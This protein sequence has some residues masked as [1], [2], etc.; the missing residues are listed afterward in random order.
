M[1]S[2][3]LRTCLRKPTPTACDQRAVGVAQGLLRRY[4]LVGTCLV[5]LFLSPASGIATAS[6][7]FDTQSIIQLRLTADFKTLTSADDES[8]AQFGAATL[9]LLQDNE[10]RDLSVAL[11]ARGK[12]R[13]QKNNCKFPL[14]FVRFGDDIQDTPFEGTRVLPLTTHC[15]TKKVYQDYLHK[16][17]LLYQ[18]FS[19][20]TD[21]SLRTRMAKIEYVD[22]G[23]NNRITESYALFVEH[24]DQAADRLQTKISVA[25]GRTNTTMSYQTALVEVFQYMIGNTDWSIPFG[26]NIL[27]LENHEGVVPVPFDFDQ[28]GAINTEYAVPSN[29]LPIKRVTQRLFRGVCKPAGISN[30]AI[31]HIASKQSEIDALITNH[32]VMSERSS[33]RMKKYFHRFFEIARQPRQREKLILNECR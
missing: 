30:A 1:P 23:R 15:Q 31:D 18:V 13:L 7:L 8:E 29:K 3:K 14:F 5:T 24:F 16:E 22:T 17:Y 32:T 27:L 19:L 25:S 21:N 20:L 26:H 9:T 2:P 4:G 12:S 10:N 11:K 28:A 33:V 6:T